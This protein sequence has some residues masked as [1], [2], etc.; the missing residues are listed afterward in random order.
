MVTLTGTHAHTATLLHTDCGTRPRSGTG[1]GRP[2][3]ERAT[4]APITGSRCQWTRDT[5]SALATVGAQ[6]AAVPHD[7]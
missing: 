2:M 6:V 4:H 5:R 7:A 1:R 3:G